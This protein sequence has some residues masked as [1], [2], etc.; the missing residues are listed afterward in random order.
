MIWLLFCSNRYLVASQSYYWASSSS[1][2]TTRDKS[3]P[4]S[5]FIS[6]ITYASMFLYLTTRENEYFSFCYCLIVK[7][8]APWLSR[9]NDFVSPCPLFWFCPFNV[10]LC[11][12]DCFSSVNFSSINCH[13]CYINSFILLSVHSNSYNTSCHV[14]IFGSFSFFCLLL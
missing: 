6:P 4:R 13:F 1:E 8:S 5:F 14:Y 3:I 2:K 10:L 11:I 12:I 9:D 7:D